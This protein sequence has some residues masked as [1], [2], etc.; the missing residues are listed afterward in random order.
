[1]LGPVDPAK[2]PDR[3]VLADALWVQRAFFS[4]TGS[5][6]P[7]GKA[8]AVIV[9]RVLCLLDRVFASASAQELATLGMPD[10]RHQW[11]LRDF[12]VESE[13]GERSRLTVPQRLLH[14]QWLM[15]AAGH[16]LRRP[17]DR[18][19][20]LRTLPGR[21][22]QDLAATWVHPWPD[23]TLQ[24]ISPEAAALRREPGPRRPTFGNALQP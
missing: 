9:K 10:D 23:G 19:F 16:L 17:P 4:R 18:R 1:L 6:T 20:I 24:W 15:S 13:R 2:A 21:I 7:W 11:Q 14:R 5:A 22:V 12:R 8:D 3:R